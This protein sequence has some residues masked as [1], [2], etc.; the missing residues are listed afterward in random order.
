MDNKASS[1]CIHCML[2]VK[3]DFRIKKFNLGLFS[4]FFSFIELGDKG[5]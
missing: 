5:N 2:Q 1:S 3:F 4:F